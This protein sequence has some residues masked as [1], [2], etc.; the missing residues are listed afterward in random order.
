MDICRELFYVI[1]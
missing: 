1:S